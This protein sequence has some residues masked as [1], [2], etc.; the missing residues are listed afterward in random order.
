MSSDS[1]PPIKDVLQAIW[2]A[3]GGDSELYDIN[4][5]VL[6]EKFEVE[7]FTTID[8]VPQIY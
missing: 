5:D 1:Y 4:P 2:V 7:G 8:Q 6:A 3:A